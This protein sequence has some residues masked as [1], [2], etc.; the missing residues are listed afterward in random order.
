[1]AYIDI[2][3]CEAV[4]DAAG[5][6]ELCAAI[7]DR[8]TEERRECA[9]GRETPKIFTIDGNIDLIS[10]ALFDINGILGRRQRLEP[11]VHLHR[12]RTC[13]GLRGRNGDRT[14]GSRSLTTPASEFESSALDEPIA[15]ATVDA[16]QANAITAAAHRLDTVSISPLLD[17]IDEEAATL[18]EDLLATLE[19]L[20]TGDVENATETL[21]QLL[22]DRF[23]LERR[24]RIM[25]A[26][27]TEPSN[28][29]PTTPWTRSAP[30]SRRWRRSIATSLRWHCSLAPSM[31]GR[32]ES[33]RALPAATSK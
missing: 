15:A 22:D 31:V 25:P 8:P 6:G 20:R 28:S 2:N 13:P 18:I 17:D 26:A 7:Q 33:R 12:K 14:A 10:N 32:F 3:Y 21:R 19:S 11:A 4:P 1:M 24:P 29:G 27:P 9:H 23:D 30:R 5:G 16:D